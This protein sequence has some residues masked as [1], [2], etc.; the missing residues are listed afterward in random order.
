M[1]VTKF[2]TLLDTAATDSSVLSES[3]L[4]QPLR[5]MD[6]NPLAKTVDRSLL[7]NSVFFRVNSLTFEKKFPRQ[8]AFENVISTLAKENCRVI[9][10]L[11][12]NGASIDFYIG[13]APLNKGNEKFHIN[14]SEYGDLLQRAFKGNFVGSDLKEVDQSA[15]AELQ[16]DDVHFKTIIGVP[17]RNSDKEDISFQSIDRLVNIML[18]GKPSSFVSNDFHLLVVWE[19]VPGED[20]YNYRKNVEQLYNNLSSRSHVSAQSSVNSSSQKGTSR[21]GSESVGKSKSTGTST[22]ESNSKGGSKSES[23]SSSKGTSY[24]HGKSDGTSNSHTDGDSKSDTKGTSKS[25][26]STSESRSGT[27]GSSHSNTSGTSHSETRNES[28]SKN[29]SHSESGSES[30]NHSDSTSRNKGDGSSTNVTTTTGRS[31]SSTSGSSSSLTFDV[32]NKRVTDILKYIEEQLIPR[33]KR[34]EAKGMFRTAVYVG[35]GTPLNCELLS[36][37]V[38]ALAQGDKSYDA[39]V[40]ARDLKDIALPQSLE[41]TRVPLDDPRLAP[42]CELDSRPV[43][44]GMIDLGTW[45]T[46]QE[47]SMVAGF[48]QKE[49]PGLELREQVPFGLNINARVDD[50]DRIDLGFMMQEGCRL[51]S[52]RVS[53]SKKELSKHIF[54]AGTTGSGKTTTCHKLLASSAGGNDPLPFMVIEPAKTEYRALINSGTKGFESVCVFT[55]GNANGVPLRFNPL[56][57]LETETL[58]GHIDELKAAFQASFDMEAAIPNLLEQGL[59][60]VY[61]KMGWNTETGENRYLKDRADAWSK[62]SHGRYFPTLSNYIKTVIELVNEKGFDARLRDEY[63]GSIRARI[64]SLTEGAKG[65]I[66]DTQLSIDFE[67]LLDRNVI[68]E[69]E[70]VKAPEDKSFIM[71]LILSRLTAALKARHRKDPN[72]K[73]ITLVEEAHRLLSRIAP[74]ANDS[75]KMGVEMFTDLLAEIRKYGESL[76][77]VDQI[78]NK[79]ASE[80]LK[81]TNTKIIH[82]LFSRDDKDAVGDTMALDDKQRNYLSYMLPGEAVVFSQGWKKPVNVQVEQLSGV[83]TDAQE[84]PEEEVFAQGR[85]YWLEQADRFSSFVNADDSFKDWK[86]FIQIARVSQDLYRYLIKNPKDSLDADILSDL[87]ELCDNSSLFKQVITNVIHDYKLKIKLSEPNKV[88]EI[89]KFEE[90]F[91]DKFE[92][93]WKDISDFFE[94]DN[95]KYLCAMCNYFASTLSA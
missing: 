17:S 24:S 3:S 53:L 76:I 47:I 81:N 67:D 46:A 34:G 52:E 62:D 9:Y 77:V 69:L 93:L 42:Y 36:N 27:V 70:D 1:D 68:F 10:Y 26:S 60:R 43:K 90:Q 57:F 41:I 32:K 72:F 30:W 31:E 33:I 5:N 95:P 63:I 8:E 22:S 85:N 64:E 84:L 58:S 16:R 66:F 82:K 23:S 45:L 88:A 44:N 35:A 54:V 73:H 92:E 13:I 71:S 25:G 78:P 75:K 74:G 79:L 91:E 89:K 14:L 86:Q 19:S 94:S 80:V 61:E 12:G 37:T 38:L 51:E 50:E 83:K 49:V 20:I 39:P 65:R 7:E 11:K 55:V 87:H 59:Y 56:E 48:P 6:L 4:I 15:F 29:E 21:G 28:T 40:Y 18:S 2:E